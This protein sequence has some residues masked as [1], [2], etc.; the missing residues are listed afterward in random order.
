MDLKSTRNFNIAISV[1]V[2]QKKASVM[3]L[4]LCYYFKTIISY[5]GQIYKIYTC[6]DITFEIKFHHSDVCRSV[7]G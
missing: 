5:D 3:W 1:S 6:K 2:L 7:L 4:S